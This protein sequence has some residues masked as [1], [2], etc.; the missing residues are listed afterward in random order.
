MVPLQFRIQGFLL[1]AALGELY[2]TRLLDTAIIS[3]SRAAA[4]NQMPYTQHLLQ[5]IRVGL[6]K[7]DIPWTLVTAQTQDWTLF[8]N[9]AALALLYPDSPQ[10]LI[11]D[12]NAIAPPNGSR[13]VQTAIALSYSVAV[14]LHAPITFSTLQHQFLPFQPGPWLETIYRSVGRTPT[15]Y[16]ASLQL[17]QQQLPEDSLA[18]TLTGALSGSLNTV[19]DFPL[20]WLATLTELS[21]SVLGETSWLETLQGL[22]EHCLARWGGQLRTLTGEA[23][24]RHHWSTVAIAPTNQF[25]PR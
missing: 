15:D 18:L 10:Q 12:W 6:Q 16:R 25:R 11:T 20:L 7:P 9:A 3:S 8:L 21:C 19:I 24:E 14:A 17:I 13:A 2:S 23:I 4:P 22:S 5:T 1:G